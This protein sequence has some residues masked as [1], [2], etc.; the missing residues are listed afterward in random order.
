ML[1]L[2]KLLKTSGFDSARAAPLLVLAV[3]QE[4]QDARGIPVGTARTSTILVTIRDS[5]VLRNHPAVAE[6]PCFYH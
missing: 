6:S 4:H 1:G 5:L 3:P 2:M